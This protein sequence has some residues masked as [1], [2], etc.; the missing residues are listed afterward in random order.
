MEEKLIR[1]L[2]VEDNPG[3]ARLIQESLKD[4][5]AA[6]FDTVHVERLADAIGKLQDEHFDAALLDLRLPDSQGIDTFDRVHEKAPQIPVVVLTGLV[7]ETVAVSAVAH[8]AQDYL[9]KGQVD[10]DDLARSIRYAIARQSAQV[11]AVTEAASRGR[12]RVLAFIGAKGGTGTTT[13]ALNVASAIAKMGKSVIAAELRSCYGTFSTQLARTPVG[14][15][16]NLLKLDPQAIDERAISHDLVSLAFKVR[17]LFGPQT[18]EE[19]MEMT[20]EH[21]ENLTELL[22]DMADFVVVDLPCHPCPESRATLAHCDFVV[23]VVEREP[24][25]IASAKVMI[26][27]LKSWDIATK[28]IGLAF[29]NRSGSATTANLRELSTQLGCG[30]I[31]AVMQATES[32]TDAMRTGVPLTIAEPDSAAAASF[33]DIAARLSADVVSLMTF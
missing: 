18:A 10:G 29:V 25:A 4:A 30:V 6:E 12:G 33:S 16:A 7:D 20:P 8:G 27:L 17:V 22:A 28:Q 13:V 31:G 5:K 23:I 2:I 1:I 3:D 9:V 32:C 21:A 26:D 11:G 14:G 24:S 19:L 15:V